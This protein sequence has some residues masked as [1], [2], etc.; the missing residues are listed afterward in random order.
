MNND[1]EVNPFSEHGLAGNEAGL[2]VDLTL[3]PEKAWSKMSRS[4]MKKC[5]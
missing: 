5:H 4:A 2:S 1:K 3:N